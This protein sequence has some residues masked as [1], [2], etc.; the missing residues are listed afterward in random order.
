MMEMIIKLKFNPNDDDIK[1]N[2]NYNPTND[3]NAN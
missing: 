1:F 2:E 3:D